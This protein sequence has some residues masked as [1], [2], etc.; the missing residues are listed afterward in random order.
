MNSRRTILLLSFCAS[1]GASG[2]MLAAAGAG[3]EAG[4]VATQD[5]RTASETVKDQWI[6]SSIKTKLIATPGVP[7]MDI[8]VDSFKRH[9]TLR[10]A[11]RNE[12]AINKAIEVARNTDGVDSVTSKLV[13]VN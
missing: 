2:C 13:V 1:I 8:N 11:L 9:V 12:E 6:V 5:N 10:G 3:A 7:A 4:Y